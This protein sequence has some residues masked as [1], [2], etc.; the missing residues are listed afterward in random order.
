MP[1]P[2]EVDFI[3]GGTLPLRLDIFLADLK[4]SQARL[5]KVLA[6]RITTKYAGTD[7]FFVYSIDRT[8]QKANDIR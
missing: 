6:A 5:V 7:I 8:P 1:K 2:G 3:Y 4:S